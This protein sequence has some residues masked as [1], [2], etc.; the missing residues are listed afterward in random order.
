MKQRSST[1]FTSITIPSTLCPVMSATI[2]FL[3]HSFSQRSFSHY[4]YNISLSIALKDDIEFVI[5]AY[6]NRINQ[7]TFTI[8]LE[9]NVLLIYDHKTL[10]VC[11]YL[12]FK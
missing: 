6:Y 11:K 3:L 8:Y 5:W 2:I 4:L 9:L 10:Y 1:E 7:L 12:I